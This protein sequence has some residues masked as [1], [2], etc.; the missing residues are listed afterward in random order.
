MATPS[1]PHSLGRQSELRGPH[2]PS[3]RR[4]QLQALTV[5]TGLLVAAVLAFASH[6]WT[7]TSHSLVA[8]AVV[9]VVAWHV[10]AQRRWVESAVRKRLTHPDR[11]LVVYNSLLATVFTVANLTG[12]IVWIWGVEGVI[13]T[14]HDVTGIAFVPLVIGHL[15]L[16]RRRLAAKLRRRRLAHD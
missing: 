10:T 8:V 3:P 16:N 11:L 9:G 4:R 6:E 12:L 13:L 7:A 2:K 5:Y 15:V 14:V 1:V